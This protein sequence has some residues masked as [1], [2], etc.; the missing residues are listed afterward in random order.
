MSDTDSIANIEAEAAVIGSIVLDSSVL[1]AA[2]EII[3]SIDYFTIPEYQN[4]WEAVNI[5]YKQGNKKIDFVLIRDQLVKMNLLKAS[6]GVNQFVTAAENTPTAANCIYYAGIVREKYLR[7][8]AIGNAQDVILKAKDLTC[9]VEDLFGESQRLFRETYDED[10]KAQQYSMLSD[11]LVSAG[12]NTIDTYLTSGFTSL[13]EM[14]YGF[15]KGHL[16]IVGARPGHG[17]TALICEMILGVVEKTS[18]AVAVFSLEQTKKDMAD[19][20]LFNRADIDSQSCYRRYMTT[21]MQQRERDQKVLLSAYPIILDETRYLTLEVLRRRMYQFIETKK[22]ELIFVDYI[23]LVHVDSPRNKSRYDMVS[24]ISSTLKTLAMEFNVPII[25][26]CQL[27][28]AV[29]GRDDKK[30]RLNDLRESGNLEQDADVVMLLHSPSV[31]F[32]NGVRKDG[33][34]LDNRANEIDENELQIII[35]KN[36]RGRTGMIT[37]DW[38]KENGRIKERNNV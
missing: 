3:K 38:T 12:S 2:Q 14:I 7:R 26:A 32:K 18:K 21:E 11:A 24:E 22:A 37:M 4:I 16:V 5:L 1:V 36:R 20:F 29:E 27:N 31:A 17:K 30:P 28:R 8:R 23:Q 33:K 34:L 15:G 25:A 13:D 10:V 9:K 19:R 35:E 6:G